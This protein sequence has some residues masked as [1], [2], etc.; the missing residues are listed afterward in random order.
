MHPIEVNHLLSKTGYTERAA[1][2]QTPYTIKDSL[3]FCIAPKRHPIRNRNAVSLFDLRQILARLKFLVLTFEQELPLPCTGLIPL[4]HTDAKRHIRHQ[5]NPIRKVRPQQVIRDFI[6][7]TNRHLLVSEKCRALSHILLVRKEHRLRQ[8][9]KFI[10]RI[11]LNNFHLEVMMPRP[12]VAEV[13]TALKQNQ[14][15]SSNLREAKAFQ[16]MH[17]TTL[18]RQC[19][20]EV[21]LPLPNQRIADI[22]IIRHLQEPIVSINKRH[23][24][25]L[26]L[27]SQLNDLIRMRHTVPPVRFSN[28]SIRSILNLDN[29]WELIFERSK[30]HRS[31]NLLTA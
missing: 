29:D 27:T 15:V 3:A 12:Q 23:Q 26:N 5:Q 31:N 20:Q 19:S 9:D 11:R 30:S 16:R 1:T 28:S 4:L 8:E 7:R 2:R 13:P 17:A 22:G 6:S 10:F 14:F 21:P 24:R 25:L 18:I